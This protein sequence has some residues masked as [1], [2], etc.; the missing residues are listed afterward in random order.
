[1][2]TLSN[3]EQEWHSGEAIDSH[4]NQWTM[5]SL[6]SD[7][8]QGAPL[9]SEQQRKAMEAMFESAR[10]EGYQEGVSEGRQSASMEINAILD[11]LQNCQSQFEK[12]LSH[13]DETVIKNII[14]LS[15]NIAEKIVRAEI[16]NKPAL[17]KVQMDDALSV[18]SDT[19]A[20]V[21]IRMHPEDARALSRLIDAALA[22]G[23]AQS[24]KLGIIE[25]HSMKRGDCAL[26]TSLSLV[27]STIREKLEQIG[28]QLAVLVEQVV[29]SETID[30]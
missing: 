1:M 15:T 13:L 24:R 2:M 6:V 19:T 22:E 17:M 3:S 21:S 27:E 16:A 11:I 14:E 29:C 7:G 12:P 26:N 18:L 30:K 4:V 8:N 28:E 23:E 10:Q 20:D 25:D 9:S 5:P